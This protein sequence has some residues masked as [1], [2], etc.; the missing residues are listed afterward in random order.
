VVVFESNSPVLHDRENSAFIKKSGKRKAFHV[1]GNSS[2]RQHIR[3]HYPIYQ[4]RCKEA[5]I[6]EHHWAVPRH[7]WRER[8]ANLAKTRKQGTLDGIAVKLH[9][10][11]KLFTREGLRHAVCQ[12]IACDD[13]VA[14]TYLFANAIL[15][16]V[17]LGSHWPLQIRPHSGTAWF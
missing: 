10:G 9:G 16:V 6:S 2:C 4:R 5:N 8:Q 15:N 13:Q 1:G 12:F 17:Q 3:Q 11:P 14:I 7:I